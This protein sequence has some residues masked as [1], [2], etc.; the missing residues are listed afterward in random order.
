[1]GEKLQVLVRDT[2]IR[3]LAR[4][5]AVT[6][7][8]APT[9]AL[10]EDETAC[11]ILD[12]SFVPSPPSDPANKFLPQVV[13]WIEDP[14]GNF[15]ETI[16]ITQATGT[17]GIGNR[18]GR[19]DFNSG[20]FWPYGRRI[21]TFPVWSNK[22]PLRW[23]ELGFQ[24]TSDDNLSHSSGQSSQDFHFCRPLHPEEF[25]A[26]TCPSERSL[27]DK[28]IFSPAKQS[29]YPPRNDLV[30]L[31]EDSPSVEM[32]ETMN[33]FDLIS[34]PTPAIGADARVSYAVPPELPAGDY[35]LWIEVSKEFDMNAAY[36]ASVFPAPNVSFSDYGQPY[37]G[38]P[39]VVY[40]VPFTMT[41][42]ETTGSAMDY[43]GYGDPDGLDGAIRP[44]D[45]TISTVPG[46][47]AARLALT[48]AGPEMYRV[49]VISRREIDLVP[50]AA[51]Q[52]TN[53]SDTSS[54]KVTLTF[55]APGDDGALGDVKGYEVRYRVGD[56]ITEDNF[57]DSSIVTATFEVVPAGEQQL[58]TV[59]G[60]LPDTEYSI[61]IRAF[62]N[63][64]NSSPLA[65]VP[66]TTDERLAGE[67]DACFIATA[68]YG[69]MMANDVE[70]LRSFRDSL[71]AKT[72]LGELAIETYY[73][74]S[75]P[76]AGIVG[77]SDLLRETARGF[78]A[79]IVE[80]V[81]QR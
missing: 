77:E 10:A 75:P 41:N 40:R 17:Y 65:V 56:V 22:Q 31:S 58:V 48:S 49:Q 36:N 33:P 28:G 46:S 60:L 73:T 76:L 1:M 64:R 62:D 25:D 13:A 11:R 43:F 71:L 80:R 23:P 78:L 67:V 50:P 45:D 12:L 81:R 30:L 37:R 2:R 26:L 57:G 8:C 63:C 68:A 59:E 53:V 51:L 66:V 18:P 19:F 69:S 61:G 44:P 54:S 6:A 70:H 34:Q 27:T 32:F 16:Y 4:I 7:A 15:V 35:V 39:S 52:E 21:T 74:F 55:T 29:A 24:D 72:V 9:L 47:G 5:A 79:P 3:Q 42:V 20:P 14:A 38:Q